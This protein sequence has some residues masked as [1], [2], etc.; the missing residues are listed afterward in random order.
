MHK[1]KWKY[2]DVRDISTFSVTN[3]TRGA[4]VQTV[5]ERSATHKK[6]GIFR[7]EMWIAKCRSDK[8]IIE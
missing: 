3:K 1:E 4:F 2:G 5:Q 6:V 7:C 8:E